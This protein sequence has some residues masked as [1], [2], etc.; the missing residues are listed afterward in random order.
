[1]ALFHK[2][3]LVMHSCELCKVELKCLLF[4]RFSINFTE[5]DCDRNDV[6]WPELA[7]PLTRYYTGEGLNFLEIKTEITMKTTVVRVSNTL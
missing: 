1:M 4:C 2:S 3:K 5:F 7:F 6:C